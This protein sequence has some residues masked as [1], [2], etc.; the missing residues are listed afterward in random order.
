MFHSAGPKKSSMSPTKKY[1]LPFIII[2]V[3]LGWLL[4]RMNI[5]SSWE[6]LWTVGLAAAGIYLIVVSG[7]NRDTFL[8]SVFLLLCSFFS[9]LRSLGY[10]RLDFEIPTLV[11]LFGVLMAIRNSDI[12][13]EAKKAAPKV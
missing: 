12:I 7:F 4:E 6:L 13:P 11:I 1:L 8:S 3:G 9:L 5:V 10:M 2:A